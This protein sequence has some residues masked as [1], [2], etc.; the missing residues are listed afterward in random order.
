V[1][2]PVYCEPVSRVFPGNREI[3]REFCDLRA[4]LD[5]SCPEMMGDQNILADQFPAMAIRECS[6]L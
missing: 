5:R 4:D 3:N 2:E 6:R 1:V